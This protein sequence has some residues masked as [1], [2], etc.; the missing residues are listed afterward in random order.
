MRLLC[1]LGRHKWKVPKV[2]PIQR[3]CVYC[4]VLEYEDD[5]G[6]IRTKKGVRYVRRGEE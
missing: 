4:L 3:Y 2:Y 6:W 1:L 5:F